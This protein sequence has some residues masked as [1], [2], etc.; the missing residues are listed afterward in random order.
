MEWMQRLGFSGRTGL[1]LRNW[2]YYYVLYYYFG[3]EGN[4]LA[5][6]VCL[7]QLKWLWAIAYLGYFSYMAC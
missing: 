6:N 5:K 4:Q 7:H 1:Q 2:N 3:L